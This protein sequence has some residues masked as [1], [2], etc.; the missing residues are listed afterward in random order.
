M[1][2]QRQS[3]TAV[4]ANQ[5]TRLHCQ[6]DQTHTSLYNEASAINKNA[7]DSEEF[8]YFFGLETKSSFL[9]RQHTHTPKARKFNNVNIFSIPDVQ[10]STNRLLFAVKYANSYMR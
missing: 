6:L 10:D 5:P 1:K 9:L 7:L 4:D 3:T 2:N 8:W